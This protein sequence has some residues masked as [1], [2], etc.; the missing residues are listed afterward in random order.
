MNILNI[1]S[2]NRL[3]AISGILKLII[4]SNN[5]DF[6]AILFIAGGLKAPAE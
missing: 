2:S 6:I 1:K 5:L 3:Q 4:N